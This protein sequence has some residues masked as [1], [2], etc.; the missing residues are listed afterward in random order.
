MFL[1]PGVQS[2]GRWG[3]VMGGQDFT[4]DTYVDG[5]PITNAVVQ[6]EGRNL[7]FGISVEVD[8]AVPGGDQ[9]HGRDVSTARARRTTSSSPGRTSSVAALRVLPQQ[10]ARFEGV[11][12]V[13]EARRQPARVRFHR[14]RTHP[15][16]P[17]VLLLG[18][19]RLPGPPAD[20]AAAGVDPHARPAPRRFQRAAGRHLRSAHDQAEP[21]RHRA[22]SAILSLAT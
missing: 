7:S 1:M 18:V 20:R 21:G 6:G 22:S 10:G 17:D 3:N 16:Q 9:R 4:N 2:V 15:A 8:R 5:I 11:L 12:R 19:R 13:G 14:W